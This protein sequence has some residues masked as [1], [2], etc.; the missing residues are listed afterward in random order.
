MDLAGLIIIVGFAILGAIVNFF[1]FRAIIISAMK[2]VFIDLQAA[3][4]AIRVVN[5]EAPTPLQHN[6]DSASLRND[7]PTNQKPAVRTATTL[8]TSGGKV[9]HRESH[10]P[11]V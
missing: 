2:Q 1:F 11:T 4:A 5:V 10:D 8:V 3:N 7:S 6:V 9:F